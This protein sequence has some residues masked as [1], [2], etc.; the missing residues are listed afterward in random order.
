MLKELK[1]SQV[2]QELEVQAKERRESEERLKLAEQE[3]TVHKIVNRSQNEASAI[4][5]QPD[6]PTKKK[7]KKWKISNPWEK[8]SCKYKHSYSKLILP[9]VLMV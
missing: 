1:K 6:T 8:R 9:N 2:T 7:S 4:L 5:E 3:T